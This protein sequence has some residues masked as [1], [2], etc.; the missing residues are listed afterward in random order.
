LQSMYEVPPVHI[1]EQIE[2][3]LVKGGV[4]NT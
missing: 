3:F 1:Q 4:A 2:Q